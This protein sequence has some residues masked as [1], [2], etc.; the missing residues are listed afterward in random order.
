MSKIIF[1]DLTKPLNSDELT[2]KL[3]NIVIA[4]IYNIGFKFNFS[5]SQMLLIINQA[6]EEMLQYFLIFNKIDEKEYNN[7]RHKA[8]ENTKKIIMDD[9]ESGF[10]DEIR[11]L[12]DG[13][14]DNVKI[15]E[16]N[17]VKYLRNQC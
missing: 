3:I 11:I 2:N 4:N 9:E 17:N 16:K 8:I 6:A 13:L 15:H 14:F 12:M 5:P 7:V 1:E 10:L